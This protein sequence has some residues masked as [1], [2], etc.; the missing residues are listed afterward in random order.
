[1]KGV[2]EFERKIPLIESKHRVDDK[3]I[4]VRTPLGSTLDTKIEL[5]IRVEFEVEALESESSKKESS[6]WSSWKESSNE[7][8]ESLRKYYK[9]H[10][11][12]GSKPE[13]YSFTRSSWITVL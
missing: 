11:E 3:T 6:K 1:M 8:L 4:Y 5:S 12:A 9:N 2:A 13:D 10:I 7:R